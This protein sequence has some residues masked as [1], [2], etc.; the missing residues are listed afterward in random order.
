MTAYK[1]VTVDAP[2]W[3]FGK[4]LEQAFLAVFSLILESILRYYF[5][6]SFFFAKADVQLVLQTIAA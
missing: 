3:G 2:Y 5:Q 1:L 4:R 6:C